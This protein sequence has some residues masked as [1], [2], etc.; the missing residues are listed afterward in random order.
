MN[1]YKIK[2]LNLINKTGVNIL[3]LGLFFN[4]SGFLLAQNEKAKATTSEANS[5]KNSKESEL[6]K[7]F[8][9]DTNSPYITEARE[10]TTIYLEAA[11]NELR[12]I[13]I[14]VI[15]YGDAV[16]NSGQLFNDIKSDYRKILFGAHQRDFLNVY[17]RVKDTKKKI[18]NFYAIFSAK[19]KEQVN[20]LL[21]LS[22]DKL[23]DK[24]MAMLLDR[25]QIDQRGEQIYLENEKSNQRLRL[26]YFNNNEAG[27]L[28]NLGIPY[29]S[30]DHYRLSK[31]YCIEV[32]KNFEKEDSAKQ[33]LETK[34]KREL[35]DG[36]GL[37]VK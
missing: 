37:I 6:P 3:V 35:I 21:N 15:N 28:S 30:I 13:N 32:M 16:P 18:H 29:Y 4:I 12:R 25:G 26:A 17:K 7:E 22:T 11:K 14:L 23:V 31:I 10:H 34:Y 20:E 5:N 36:R 19:Y 2:K 33:A 9:M 27:R 8:A 1:S 24:E